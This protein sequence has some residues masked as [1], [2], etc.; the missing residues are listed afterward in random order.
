MKSWLQYRD[1]I[2]Y[3]ALWSC[4]KKSATWHAHTPVTSRGEE[5]FIFILRIHIAQSG[6]VYADKNPTMPHECYSSVM[7]NDTRT[8]PLWSIWSFIVHV[9][10]LL[11][12]LSI[13][14]P[15]K[16]SLL[17]VAS[18]AIHYYELPYSTTNSGALWSGWLINQNR[19][20][21]ART[22]HKLVCTTRY[23]HAHWSYCLMAIR[24]NSG[25]VCQL[26]PFS[27]FTFKR[28]SVKIMLCLSNSLGLYLSCFNFNVSMTFSALSRFSSL[29]HFPPL[30]VYIL[31]WQIISSRITRQTLV[32]FLELWMSLCSRSVEVCLNCLR[33]SQ[34]HFN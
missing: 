6:L 3:K 10:P 29:L 34:S 25:V 11:F 33:S 7:N 17:T 32:L 27:F 31:K 20:F 4:P 8:F 26:H 30:W 15:W 22:K 23:N 24:A 18:R 1:D 13:L 28:I 5:K 14:P 21:G 19:R 12:F 16:L 9:A 2:S